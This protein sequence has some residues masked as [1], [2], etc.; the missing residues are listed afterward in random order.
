[1]IKDRFY[2]HWTVMLKIAHLLPKLHTY[3]MVFPK[4]YH[5]V[6][7]YSF[8]RYNPAIMNKKILITALMIV[9]IFVLIW[10]VNYLISYASQAKVASI[11]YAIIFST[12]FYSIN[13]LVL[14]LI[15]DN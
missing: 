7:F 3:Q 2:F 9:N 11:A 4:S 14:K 13:M 8:V 6:I 5:K 10:S 12:A 15:K 1:M